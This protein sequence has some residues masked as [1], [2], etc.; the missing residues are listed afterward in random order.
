[1]ARPKKEGMDYFPH[2]TDA[3]NDEKIEA[4]RF[5]Y[6]NDGYAFY[7]ILL[8][9][10]YRAKEFELDVSDAE[11]IQILCRKIGVNEEKFHQILETSLKRSCFDRVAYEEKRVLTSTGI[12]N[13]ASIVVEKRV[14]MRDKYQKSKDVSDAETSEETKVETS[15]SKVKKRKEKERNKNN[16][17]E[18]IK[19]LRLRYSETQLKVIDD[20]LEIIR[21]TRVSAK[22]SESVIL[23]MYQDWDKYPTICV[24]YGLKTHTD[25]PAFHSKKENYTI[26]IIRN[27]TAD[28]AAEKMKPASPQRRTGTGF[29]K[30]VVNFTALVG[31]GG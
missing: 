5:L 3:V 25:N 21:H 16:I 11:T 6:G 23:K 30:N 8:E 19:N 31:N 17:P 26:G 4:L 12:K 10:I 18:Q 27:T 20:Y 13:R 24:E 14:M 15:Q 9:R 22:I 1:M 28:E 2:D 29:N 7:F